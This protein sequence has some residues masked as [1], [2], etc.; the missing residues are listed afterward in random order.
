MRERRGSRKEWVWVPEA[1]KAEC[2]RDEEEKE[3]EEKEEKMAGMG[4]VEERYWS[5]GSDAAAA[6]ATITTIE[7]GTSPGEDTPS[8]G[9][10]V[11]MP[12]KVGLDPVSV[13]EI[14]TERFR[15]WSVPV[16]PLLLVLFGV[17]AWVSGVV[18]SLAG[19]AFWDGLGAVPDV[20]AW[21]LVAPL[22]T[23]LLRAVSEVLPVNTGMTM[24]AFFLSVVLVYGH[25]VTQQHGAAESLGRV[26]GWAVWAV[27]GVGV[28]IRAVVRWRAALAMATTEGGVAFAPPVRIT[29]VRWEELAVVLCG[30]V[31]EEGGQVNGTE[32]S[33]PLEFVSTGDIVPAVGMCP[34]HELGVGAGTKASGGGVGG[35]F[36]LGLFLL[37][38]VVWGSGG[39]RLRGSREGR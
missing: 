34:R 29:V 37:G 28:V 35:S 39:K 33:L 36:G 14:G 2:R 18:E 15:S 12:T 4:R 17:V 6:T 32:K 13:S 3:E 22:E 24:L 10:D 26:F 8:T 20:P 9:E 7:A 30:V 5:W 21:E 1:G 11:A 27:S 38:F 19:N 31:D 23:V 16:G 25:A